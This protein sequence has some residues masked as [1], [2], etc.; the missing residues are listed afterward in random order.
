[1]SDDADKAARFEEMARSEG[2]SKAISQLAEP[3]Q[4]M[5]GGVVVCAWCGSPIPPE[6]LKAKPDS[7][8]C[9]PCKSILET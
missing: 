8:Y 2:I 5:D 1:M 9:V 7:A 6:R 3:E 4:E